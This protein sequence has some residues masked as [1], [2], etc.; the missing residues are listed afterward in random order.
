MGTATPRGPEQEALWTVAQDL[1]AT[2]IAE[3]LKHSGLGKTS[4]PFSGGPGEEQFSSFLT[5]EHARLFTERGGIGLAESIFRA[6]TAQ[7]GRP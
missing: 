6:L 7:A 4:G 5:Q 2:F 1:E 3:M